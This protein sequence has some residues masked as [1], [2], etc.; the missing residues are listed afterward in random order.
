MWKLG[1]ALRPIKGKREIKQTH[2]KRKV[3]GRRFPPLGKSQMQGKARRAVPRPLRT[4][5]HCGPRAGSGRLA[6]P[7]DTRKVLEVIAHIPKT[8]NILFEIM[9]NVLCS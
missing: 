3:K 7:E 9:T 6:E 2:I 1:Q 5:L 8:T 4:W